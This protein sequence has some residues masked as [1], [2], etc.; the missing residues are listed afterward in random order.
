MSGESF[1]APQRLFDGASQ[2]LN[3]ASGFDLFPDGSGFVMV[4][5]L[6]LKDA[7]AV[8]VQNWYGEFAGR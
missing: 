7:A 1:G 2:Q 6:P 5:L 3:A 4:K 8:Y